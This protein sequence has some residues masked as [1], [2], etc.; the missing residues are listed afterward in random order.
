MKFI[1]L[2]VYKIIK[3]RTTVVNNTIPHLSTLWEKG[4]RFKLTT[5]VNSNNAIA[6]YG[7]SEKSRRKLKYFSTH[8]YL[9]RSGL[10]NLRFRVRDLSVRELSVHR[11][12]SKYSEKEN[13]ELQI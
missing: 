12:C 7:S 13:A 2:V 6:N 5:P 8:D 10:R 3:P 11:K 9:A 4:Q 1:L